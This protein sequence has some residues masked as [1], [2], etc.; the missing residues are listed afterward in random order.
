MRRGKLVTRPAAGSEV[1]WDQPG[2]VE[3][4]IEADHLPLWSVER[5]GAARQLAPG[6]RDRRHL[7]GA[8]VRDFGVPP[9]AMRR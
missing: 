1:E 7:R 8:F 9:Q 3:M 5:V 2:V 6:F 4:P